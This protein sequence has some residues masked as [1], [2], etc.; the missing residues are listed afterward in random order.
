MVGQEHP[1][2]G[3]GEAGAEL[4]EHQILAL[5]VGEE[6][7]AE[8]EAQ[9]VMLRMIHWSPGPLEEL[10]AEEAAAAAAQESSLVQGWPTSTATYHPWH[11]TVEGVP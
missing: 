7:A 1:P 10:L 4:M 3:E 2:E 9:M 5:E 6:E 11:S 8:A